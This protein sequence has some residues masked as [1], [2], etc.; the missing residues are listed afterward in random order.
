MADLA[1]ITAAPAGTQRRHSPTGSW[2]TAQIGDVLVEGDEI[3][4]TQ[5]SDYGVELY[6]EAMIAFGQTVATTLS[7]LQ[8]DVRY[9][10]GSGQWI[11]IG[12][13]GQY[14]AQAAGTGAGGGVGVGCG[15][16]GVVKPPPWKIS[17]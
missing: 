3:R 6:S 13:P 11:G 9:K 10:D 2:Q 1:I 5:G 14:Q 8:G 16:F 4:N 12:S 17:Q 7:N 15:Y